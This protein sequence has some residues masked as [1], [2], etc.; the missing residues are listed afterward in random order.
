LVT[1]DPVKVY[2]LLIHEHV[3]HE[4]HPFTLLLCTIELQLTRRRLLETLWFLVKLCMWL[5]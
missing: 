4:V 1:D 3:H 2:E 5:L